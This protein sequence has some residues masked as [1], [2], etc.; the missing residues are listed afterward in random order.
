MDEHVDKRELMEKSQ[1][2]VKAKCSGTTN[3]FMIDRMVTLDCH[4]NKC[5]FGVA[6]IDV[7]KAYDCVDHHWLKKIMWLHKFPKWIC[8]VVGKLCDSWNTKIAAHTV[9]GNK[10]SSSMFQQA[11]HKGMC[12]VRK[13]KLNTTEGYR[14]SKP[15]LSPISCTSMI[16]RCSRCLKE[17]WTGCWR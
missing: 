8:E 12:C 5:N 11:S 10:L 4:W 17:S 2:G 14:L 16:L 9:K 15:I 3:N 13:W 1:R 7:C 6:W